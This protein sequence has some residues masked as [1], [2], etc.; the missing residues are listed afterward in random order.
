MRKK[1]LYIED[2][3]RD[4]ELT[5]KVF[6]DSVR[7]CWIKKITPLFEKIKNNLGDYDKIIVDVNLDC[8]KPE[9]EKGIDII[10]ELRKTSPNLEIICISSENKR[11]KALEAG[12]NRFIYKKQFWEENGR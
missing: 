6:G 5:K 4:Y 9:T 3:K 8:S 11:K 7:V 12:A 10:K 1:V 2:M